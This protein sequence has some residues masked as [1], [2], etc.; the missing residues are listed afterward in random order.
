MT[1]SLGFF[2]PTARCVRDTSQRASAPVSLP[3]T[4]KGQLLAGCTSIV[5]MSN[6][7]IVQA[8]SFT[9]ETTRVLSSKGIQ[10]CSDSGFL[11]VVAPARNFESER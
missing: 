3:K 11:A 8:D 4:P 2:G 10:R 1:R 7:N 9:P 6:S 5:P